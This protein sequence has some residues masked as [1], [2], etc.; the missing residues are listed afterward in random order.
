[1]NRYDV[2][3]IGAGVAGCAIARELA[4][5]ELKVAV[6]DKNS[7]VCEGTSKANSGIIHAGYD[8]KPGTLK[9]KLNVRGSEMMPVIAQQ[10]D[11]PFKRNGSMVV[12]EC[13]EDMPALKALYERGLENGVKHLR[14][15]DKEEALK[16]E[17]NLSDET[18]GVLLAETGGIVCPFN[19]TIAFAEHAYVNG[20][21]FFLNTQVKE[22][23]EITT[24]I[25]DDDASEKAENAGYIIKAAYYDQTDSSKDKI[26]VYHTDYVVN[27]AGVHADIIHNMVSED[28][29]KIT[30]RKGEYCLLD[31][32]AGEHVSRTIFKMPGALGKGILVSPT[33]HGNLLV[34]PTAEDLDDKEGNFTTSEG[35]S[36]VNTVGASAVKNVPM[37]QVITSFAGLRPHGDRGDFIIEELK[38]HPG[39]IDAA[40]IESPGLSAS[41]AI[42][43]MVCKM[44]V[45]KINPVR[46]KTYIPGRKGVTVMKFLPL[47]K[48][49]EIIESDPR[50]ANI[51]CRCSSITEGEIIE[52]IHRPL[53]ATTMDGVKRRTGANMGRCQGG[54]CYPKVMEIL[55]RELGIPLEKVTKCGRGSEIVNGHIKEDR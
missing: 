14:L 15:L 22:I 30:P 9:A 6:L 49:Y 33:I 39:F 36:A 55:S 5:Y 46:K 19:M 44:I 20:V 13:E 50:Y 52:T 42:G 23:N 10:L 31:V 41:P 12:C 7:D 53:G 43:E 38:N 4:R 17:P 3:I 29:I 1:M 26:V 11:I 37:N 40:G 24:S 34:G 18:V 51:I 35:L 21:D 47:E 8:A 54:F 32:T 16:L 2:V 45:D 27:A 25:N 28:K 48:Q